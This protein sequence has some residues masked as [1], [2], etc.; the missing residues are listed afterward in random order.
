M[1]KYDI[2]IL[3]SGPAGIEIE[4]MLADLTKKIAIVEKKSATFGGACVNHGCMPTK[5][6]AKCADLKNTAEKAG[7]YGVEM[8]DS[9]ESFMRIMKEKVIV[10]CFFRYQTK[11]IP[12]LNVAK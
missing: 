1:E 11:R 5:H 12:F 2:I 6:L 10:N 3:G 8:T 9:T 4:T 7:E